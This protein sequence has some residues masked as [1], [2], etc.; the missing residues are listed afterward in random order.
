MKETSNSLVSKKAT[1][2]PHPFIT[3][4][5]SELSISSPSPSA[6]TGLCEP[7]LQIGFFRFF[8]KEPLPGWA[9]FHNTIDDSHAK[10]W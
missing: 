1:P 5:L 2:K 4:S 9:G 3:T 7:W 8:G 10:S 6:E